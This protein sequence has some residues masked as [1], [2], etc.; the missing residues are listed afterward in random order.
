[1]GP[2]ASRVQF[3]KIQR[4]IQT[5]IDEGAHVIAGGTGRPEGHEVG[6][7]VRPTVFA[8]VRNDMT[9]AREEIFGPVLCILGYDDLDQAV[10]IGNDTEYGLAGYV[11]GADLDQ[12]RTLARQIRAGTVAINHALDLGAPFG[13]YKQSGNGREWG[14]FGFHEFLETKGIVGYGT[15]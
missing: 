5:G 1:L 14:E 2:V 11:S 9:I 3:D 15:D 8:D 7:Y 10:Q 4:L 12:A 6:Y 13:G